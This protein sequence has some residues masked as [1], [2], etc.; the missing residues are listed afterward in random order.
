MLISKVS[1][2]KYLFISY[3]F[4]YSFSFL[5]EAVRSKLFIDTSTNFA[6]DLAALNIQRGRDH[7]LPPYNAYRELCG[8]PQLHDTWQNEP[9]DDFID[10]MKQKLIDAGYRY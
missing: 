8:R 1:V 6:L 2:Q 4:H 5:V 9:L 3:N 7:G 10:G